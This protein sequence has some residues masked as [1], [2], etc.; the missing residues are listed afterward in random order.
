MVFESPSI[1]ICGLTCLLYFV[2]DPG[3]YLKS[4]CVCGFVLCSDSGVIFQKTVASQGLCE[5][6][7]LILI[8]S[9]GATPVPSLQQPLCFGCIFLDVQ[10]QSSF[11]VP[12]GT[13]WAVTDSGTT[14]ALTNET[15][16]GG[17]TLSGTNGAILIQSPSSFLQFETSQ[18]RCTYTIPSNN[19][20]TFIATLTEAGKSSLSQ[21]GYLHHILKCYMILGLFVL[22]K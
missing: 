5:M 15:V 2:L 14:M 16:V 22:C 18:L 1:V 21:L 11:F 20:L 12:L 10:S 7:N 4:A 9:T 13:E 17:I 8:S 19:V 3:T 6:P